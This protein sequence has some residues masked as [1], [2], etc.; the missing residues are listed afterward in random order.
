MDNLT[1]KKYHVTINFETDETFMSNVPAHRVVIDE[2]VRNNIVEHYTVSIE[3]QKSWIV[4]NAINR[5]EVTELL[6]RS[7]LYPYWTTIE[8]DEIFVVD[9]GMYRL[10]K[11][12]YN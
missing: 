1:Y 4:I 3:V 8:I 10:P 5:K 9:G 7:P 11:M 6:R 2:Y 12:Q